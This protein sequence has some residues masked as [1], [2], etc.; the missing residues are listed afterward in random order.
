[1]MGVA[2]NTTVTLVVTCHRLIALH[3]LIQLIISIR[4][5]FLLSDIS[6][7]IVVR[8]QSAVADVTCDLNLTFTPRF[9]QKNKLLWP[10]GVA[11][12]VN[13]RSTSRP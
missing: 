12:V 4:Q 10:P 3:E 8:Q 2:Y 5:L 7:I 9:F 1:M 11:V 6:E 13:T